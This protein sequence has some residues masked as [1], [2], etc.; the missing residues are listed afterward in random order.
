VA[1]LSLVAEFDRRA[2][3]PKIDD[4]GVELGAL[5]KAAA[6]VTFPARAEE[7][8][9][10]P[11]IS[12]TRDKHPYRGPRPCP[13]NDKHPCRS[14]GGVWGWVRRGMSLAGRLPMR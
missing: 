7:L 11:T 12:R 3:H 2:V 10:V 8:T 14:W 13:D 6:A 1:C 4:P 5:L 9:T